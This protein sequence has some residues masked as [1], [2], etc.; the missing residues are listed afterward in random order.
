MERE[1]E[2]WFWTRSGGVARGRRLS[3]FE[4]SVV[5]AVQATVIAAIVNHRESSFC[6]LIY[7]SYKQHICTHWREV[8]R[9]LS[10]GHSD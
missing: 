6:L 2:G 8:H 7:W 3:V 1:F 4:G 9:Q 10:V 5:S